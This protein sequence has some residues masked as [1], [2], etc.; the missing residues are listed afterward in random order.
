VRVGG[1]AQQELDLLVQTRFRR[2]TGRRL[3]FDRNYTTHTGASATAVVAPRPLETLR[4]VAA[5]EEIKRVRDLLRLEHQ[6]IQRTDCRKRY[7]RPLNIFTSRL[8]ARGCLRR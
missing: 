6:D 8:D 5:V 4:E 7:S 1:V 3:L 2:E